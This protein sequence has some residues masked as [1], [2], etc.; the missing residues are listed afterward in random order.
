MASFPC[1]NPMCTSRQPTFGTFRGLEMHYSKSESCREFMLKPKNTFKYSA[2][3]KPNTTTAGKRK[4]PPNDEFRGENALHPEPSSMSAESSPPCSAS[5]NP[6]QQCQNQT[7]DETQN[8]DFELTGNESTDDPFFADANEHDN[9]VPNFQDEPFWHTPEQ[10]CLIDLMKLLIDMNAPDYA[11]E[12]IIEWARRS[13]NLGFDFVPTKGKTWKCNVKWM[14]EMTENGGL[15]LPKIIPVQLEG[16][17]I[18]EVVCFDFIAAALGKLQD[19]SMMRKEKLVLDWDNPLDKYVPPDGRLGEALSGS[20]Y[21]DNHHRFITDPKRPT[22]VVPLI[23]WFDR[24]H[25]TANGKFGLQPYMF[26]FGIFNEETRRSLKAWMVLGYMPA[27]DASSAERNT[28]KQGQ[29]LRD[30]HTQLGVMLKSFKDN[31]FTL[32]DQVL[33]VGPSGSTT[34]DVKFVILHVIQ[35]ME[36]GDRLA[37]RFKPHTPGIKRQV[38]ACN[39]NYENLANPK[40]ICQFVT[41]KQMKKIAESEDAELRQ[42]WSMH[43]IK[44]CFHEIPFMDAKR[45]IFGATP[46]EIL[47]CVRM[48]PLKE[49]NKAVFADLTDGL[50]KK[51]DNM[52]R[53][54]HKNNR[55]TYRKAYP[56]TNF[57]NGVTN[58]SLISGDEHVGMMFLFVILSNFDEGWDLL[59]EIMK[60]KGKTRVIHVMQLFEAVL[61]FHAWLCKPKQWHLSQQQEAMEA[62]QMSVRQLMALFVKRLPNEKGQGWKVPK[63]HELL[64]FVFDMARFGST[65]NFSA[66]R[67]ESLLKDTGKR[68]GRKAQKNNKGVVF[69]YQSADRYATMVMVDLL[70][71]KIGSPELFDN[72]PDQEPSDSDS[73]DETEVPVQEGTGQGTFAT[74]DW[75]ETNG[76]I[77]FLVNW[78][79]TSKGDISKLYLPDPIVYF[80]IDSYRNQ[81]IKICTEYRRNGMKFRCHPNFQNRGPM[82]D[83]LNIFDPITEE[84]KPALL[85]AVVVHNEKKTNVRY[86]LIVQPVHKRTGRD[87][88]LFTE[89]EVIP[90][91]KIVNPENVVSPVFVIAI[92]PDSSRVIEA[93]AVE[94]WADQ[95]TK[96]FDEPKEE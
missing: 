77:Q 28:L 78:R 29:Y 72:N 39:V 95:F 30:Y 18:A 5:I 2:N 54:F 32:H 88:V 19:R 53:N 90:C 56:T 24:T 68:V 7:L 14:H 40:I 86:D 20:V 70:H 36:E 48:G 84:V 62:A 21:Q 13:A 8:F 26:T 38:R 11:F 59:D 22:L 10:K 65:P 42:R 80:L 37:G 49:A 17:E 57:T 64:H 12:Q 76:D 79:T 41:A 75:T 81:T 3:G 94:K 52:A 31:A 93:L 61:C 55:Q 89:W 1:A 96:S 15:R 82:Y 9:Q 4:T 44:N 47:H 6:Q 23:S 43:H 87:S 63:F 33:P 35:D 91:S 74:I 71:D 58:L 45:G 50:K 51:L 60:R 83:W 69:E 46:S 92:K 67:P 34:C 66:Q 73:D 27:Y 16:G 25:V 85:K